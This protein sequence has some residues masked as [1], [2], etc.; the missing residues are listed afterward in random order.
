MMPHEVMRFWVKRRNKLIYPY[1]LV[2]YLLL[3]NQT[4]MAQAQQN[5]S[6]L[7]S[8][9]VVTLIKR[10]IINS[11]L[12]GKEK[13]RALSH[14]ITMFWAEVGYFHNKKKMFC[15]AYMWDTQARDHT[16]AF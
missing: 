13:N 16:P 4:I 9:A 1:S 2:G 11:L 7:H 3:P 6:D 12:V 14:A 10:L 8:R 5:R 15:P